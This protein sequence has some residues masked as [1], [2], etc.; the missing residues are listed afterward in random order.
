MSQTTT[1]ESS[2]IPI[3]IHLL[4]ATIERLEEISNYLSFRKSRN[5]RLNE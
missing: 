2:T 3:T 5:K 1:K 4:P